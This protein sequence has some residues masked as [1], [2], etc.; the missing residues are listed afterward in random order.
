MFVRCEA[1]KSGFTSLTSTNPDGCVS[2][3]C[4]VI[5]SEN[6]ICDPITSNC[7]C[8]PG[9]GGIRC[10][11]CISGFHSFSTSGCQACE[12]NA[13]GSVSTTCDAA[14]GDCSC[15]LNVQGTNC[16]TCKD[17]FFD[18]NAFNTDGYGLINLFVTIYPPTRILL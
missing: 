2:C 7:Q 15:K 4:N 18:L 3:G 9:V 14:T 8:R 5:G 16:D 11:T 10:D 6:N 17:G 13:I 1:C 12:C